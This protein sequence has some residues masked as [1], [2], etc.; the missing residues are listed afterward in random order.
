MQ[1]YFRKITRLS[2]GELSE[3]L[4]LLES[5]NYIRII[6]EH[7]SRGK[8]KTRIQ[9]NPTTKLTKLTKADTKT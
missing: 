5:L 3:P 4:S 8:P 9:I 1:V 6:E 2:A 7:S